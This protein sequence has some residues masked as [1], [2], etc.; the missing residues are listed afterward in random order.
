MSK[1]VFGA[2]DINIAER[3]FTLADIVPAQAW[4]VPIDGGKTIAV[5]SHTSKPVDGDLFY[6]SWKG[7]RLFRRITRKDGQ[8]VLISKTRQT[9]I[10]AETQHELE[11]IG[12]VM[13]TISF[14]NPA[15]EAVLKVLDKLIKPY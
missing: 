14:P 11:V 5:V 13:F 1:M 6:I 12:R 15:T 7:E 9:P 4:F 10:P 8:V 2:K 3:K